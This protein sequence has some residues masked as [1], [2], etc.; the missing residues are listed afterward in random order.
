[1]K[2][3][4]EKIKINPEIFYF[5]TS[6]GLI[7]NTNGSLEL[8]RSQPCSIPF[9]VEYNS[10]DANSLLKCW[11]FSTDP[12]NGSIF[13]ICEEPT[14]VSIEL[15]GVAS[16][17]VELFDVPLLLDTAPSPLLLLDVATCDELEA[18]FFCIAKSTRHI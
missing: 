17:S 8:R 9:C 14:T 16:I 6:S 18:D 15:P 2:I 1:M 12:S 11:M 7:E 4:S 3:K 5:L 13:L 10:T